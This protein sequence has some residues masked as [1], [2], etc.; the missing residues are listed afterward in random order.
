VGI[1]SG[2]GRTIV[3]AVFAVLV[4]ACSSAPPSPSPS[5]GPDQPT[6]WETVLD[7]IGVDGSVSTD[8]AL[9]MFA[10]AF[11]DMPGVELPSAPRG[12]IRSGSLAL[13]LIVAHWDE[14]T[15]E[16]KSAAMQLVPDLQ[17]ITAPSSGFEHLPLVAGL[18]PPVIQQR[19]PFYAQQRTNDF[20]TELA[21]EAVDQINSKLKSPV[22]IGFTIDAHV[23]LTEKATSAAETA[24]LDA[25]GRKD[26]VMAKC[27]IT[28]SPAG[29]AYT[30][31]ADVDSMMAHEAWH[32]IEG[33]LLGL[34]HYWYTIKPWIQE[35][36]AEWV[37][38]SLAPTAGVGPESWPRYLL[39]PG[40]SLFKRSYDAVGFY[41]QLQ[42]SGVDVWS[43]LVP[44]LQA[45]DNE[46]AFV[47][48]G[49]TKD[50][51]LDIWASG[52]LRDLGRGDP[53]EI[54]GPAVT[55][56]KA[57]PG[58]LQ[59]SNG[60]SIP[61][62]V[63]AYTNEID[64][65]GSPPDILQVTV[66]GHARI[67]DGSGHDY[68]VNDSGTYCMT[69]S[70]E[71]CDAQ[72]LNGPTPA[73]AVTG[74]QTGNTG[75]LDG[76]SSQG[77]KPKEKPCGTGGCGG[78]NGDP[79]LK[80]VDGSRYD[81]QAAGEY[82]LLRAPDGSLEIQARQE[83][84]GDSATINTA[85]A[86]K[87]NGH[88][89]AFYVADA[90]VPEVRIDG[91]VVGADEVG[92][93]D[94]GSGA[95]LAAFQR[96]Y[97]L[98]FPDGTKLWAL[99]MGSWGI[100]VLVLPSDTLRSDGAG[101]IARVPS[102]ARYRVPALPDGSQLP[103]PANHDERYQLLYGTFAP[104]WRVTAD[105]ALFDYDEGKTTDS[106]VVAD[107]PPQTAPLDISELLP[108]QLATAQQTCSAVTDTD[109]AEQ[110]A[111]DVVI[112]GDD[113]FVT[114]YIVSDQL[115]SEGTSTL[116]EPPPS[117]PEPHVTPAPTGGPL[118]SGI[119][120]VAD[121]IAGVSSRVLAPNG[122]VYAMVA[123]QDVAF[124]D[125]KYTLL[126]IDPSTGQITQQADSH[127]PGMLAWAGD[128]LWAGEFSRAEVGTCQISRLDP[129]TL[130]EQASIP[131]VCADQGLTTL[132][133]VGDA[134]WFMD[135]TGAAADGTGQ[136][137]RRIDPG[138]NAVDSSADGNLVL[139]VPVQFVNV[140][141][142]GTMWSSTSAGLLFGNRQ[143]G[144][145][146]LLNGSATFDSLGSPQGAQLAWYAAG[147]G[148]W[149]TTNTGDSGG[150][151]SEAAFYNGSDLPT[152]TIGYDGSLAGADDTAVYVE[153]QED[154]TVADSL[155]R[156]PLDGTGPVV[157]ALGGFTQNSFGGQTPLGYHD[158]LINPLLFNGSAGVKT[159]V[160]PSASDETMQQLLVQ[161][162]ELP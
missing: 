65:F 66:S 101:I 106:Y 45:I 35:G 25:N 24:A 111:F 112:T 41:S 153:Y 115:E 51:F 114:T 50:S 81:L 155:V 80:T 34:F 47:A 92:A 63:A 139:P 76:I 89:V 70:C 140:T 141:G 59:L 147:D 23:G 58:G 104:A 122:V 152:Q 29:D 125:L 149:T 17:T 55:S 31:Q 12:P 121:H 93:S 8:T 72:L 48:S 131:T 142:A 96:G 42:L 144:L 32:C 62:D 158:S 86:A 161:Q 134:V 82:V 26:G 128:S 90:G 135:S 124:G 20:Y 119:N 36:E 133:S 27:V 54:T 108:E 14:L 99:S 44:I 21:N 74:G 162:L 126:A 5:F 94:L 11:G 10:L 71:G 64:T 49:A 105:T 160:L 151:G 129:N 87:V 146:R 103:A 98:D 150:L 30:D 79:H 148:V 157:V 39:N 52:Y 77:C 67:S 22:N 97:E 53:W 73:L 78:S 136:H 138:T 132:T 33:Q 154:D 61:I 60:G 143:S 13:R 145:Y 75:Q 127:G 120:F 15:P 130:T 109:L 117:G 6:A 16:Q 113:G 7:E 9:R 38:Y 118:P 123:T 69:S 43:V 37:G 110:C 91:L 40:S 68:I 28:V 56:D 18:S 1:R 95:S 57:K 46:P 116:S 2:G 100:N 19:Q 85:V 83:P 159:W 84:R 3:A 88:R 137:L 102:D 107:F 4:A 156:Y